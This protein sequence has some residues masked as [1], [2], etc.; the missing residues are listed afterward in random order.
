MTMKGL[1]EPVARPT[2]RAEPGDGILKPVVAPE[3]LAAGR[4][5]RC[6]KNAKAARFVCRRTICARHL[7][8][9]RQRNHSPRLLSYRAQRIRKVR[10][11]PAFLIIE[12]PA[13]VGRTHVI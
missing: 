12:E 2:S 3:H 6:S 10:L 1:T 7:V 11:H 8:R 5:C 9:F 4:E 13:P